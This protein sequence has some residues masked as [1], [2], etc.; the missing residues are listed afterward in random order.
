MATADVGQLAR[1][2]AKLLGRPGLP[3]VGEH[4]RRLGDPNYVCLAIAENKITMHLL[5]PLLREAEQVGAAEGS[6]G[7]VA[8]AGYDDPRGTA[9]FRHACAAFLAENVLRRPVNADHLFVSAGIHG[10]LNALFHVLCDDGDAVLIPAPYFGGFDGILNDPRVGVEVLESRSPPGTALAEVDAAIRPDA[11]KAAADRQSGKGRV[12][13][14]LL[15]QPHNPTGRLYSAAAIREAVL[16][17]RARGVHVVSDE[18][19]AASIHDENTKHVSTGSRAVLSTDTAAE[20][21]HIVYGFSKDFGIA[22]WRVACLL[23]ENTQL[24][25][26]LSQLAHFQEVSTPILHL[27]AR[28]LRS[29]K[30]PTY[31]TSHRSRLREAYQSCCES[32][33]KGGLTYVESQSGMFVMVD[34]RRHL[35]AASWEA[36]EEVWRSILEATNVNL[37]PGKSLHFEEPGWFRICFAYKP[38][39]VVSRCV[40]QI[41]AHLASRKELES[42]R[43]AAQ[44]RNNEDAEGEAAVRRQRTAQSDWQQMPAAK[45]PSKTKLHSTFERLLGSLGRG[46][47]VLD[48]GCGDGRLSTQIAEAFG[49]RV[50][51]IDINAEAVQAAG[52]PTGEDASC[53]FFVADCTA[54]ELRIP[55][56]PFDCALMQL[57]VSVVGTTEQRRSALAAA[58][59]NLTPGGA[60]LVSASGASEKVNMEYAK[61]YQQDRA[62]SGEERTYFSRNEAGDVLYA[63]HHFQE[64][65]LRGLLQ[66]AGFDI[67]SFVAEDEASSRRP[68]QRAVFFYVVARRRA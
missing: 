10:V 40:E 62:A 52:R 41:A 32:M 16:W 63:T 46:R 19:Y 56:A 38:P 43:G 60:L 6:D 11:L 1:R 28:M 65:E 15:T 47:R 58:H 9:V 3:Y 2:A 27:M 20:D 49:L 59:A 29:P 8:T 51:G 48:V 42:S 21:V 5:E 26:A 13:A 44:K 17:A 67:E 22:G 57:L 12:R 18:V 35:S 14:L 66:S 37:T 7:R 68:D 39:G 34:L 55:G 53:D 50:T 23:S 36:E 45:I 24:R 30:L 64:E 61:L 4:I 25:A 33:K 54:A 31:L